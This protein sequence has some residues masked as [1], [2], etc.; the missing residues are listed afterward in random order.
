MEGFVEC[1][2]TITLRTLLDCYE[3][4]RV[5]QVNSQT[6]QVECLS[7][8]INEYGQKNNFIDIMAG[9]DVD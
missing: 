2:R 7:D 4:E 5:F 3:C 9:K 1:P 8:D 6:Q